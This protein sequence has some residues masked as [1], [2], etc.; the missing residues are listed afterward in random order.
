MIFVLPRLWH[1]D[2]EMFVFEE[3]VFSYLKKMYFCI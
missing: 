3:N 2:V 1:L